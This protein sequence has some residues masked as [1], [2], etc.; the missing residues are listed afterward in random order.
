MRVIRTRSFGFWLVLQLGVV[1]ATLILLV[2]ARAVGIH[3]SPMPFDAR[4]IVLA[5]AAIFLIWV[6][7]HPSRRAGS[8]FAAFGLIFVIVGVTCSLLSPPSHFLLAALLLDPSISI[9]FIGDI[10][11]GY[12]FLLCGSVSY[13]WGVLVGEPPAQVRWRKERFTIES[14][15]PDH[16]IHV[17][18]IAHPLGRR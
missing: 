8:M 12:A 1:V 16:V 9:F 4:Q 13:T 2:A 3:L 11:I 7:V 18:G 17:D 15:T 5:E 10:A 14:E 6:G